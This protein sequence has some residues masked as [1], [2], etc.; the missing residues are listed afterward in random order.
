ML[1]T[2]RFISVSGFHNSQPQLFE[3]GEHNS[4]TF[5]RENILRL[6][7]SRAEQYKTNHDELTIFFIAI[8]NLIEWIQ[9][10]HEI[11]KEVLYGEKSYH[12]V[13]G[14]LGVSKEFLI[15]Y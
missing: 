15:E 8:A 4:S 5:R 7:F 3:S 2:W 13:E 12:T 10:W 1:T 11:L 6:I 9:E 14:S